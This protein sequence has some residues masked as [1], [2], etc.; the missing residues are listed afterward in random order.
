LKASELDPEDSGIW[1]NL[2]RCALKL[3]K[4]DEAKAYSD[5]AVAL[6]SSLATAVESLL[7][8]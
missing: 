7:K 8:M 1:M 4:T 5:K 3:K 2:T 6:D